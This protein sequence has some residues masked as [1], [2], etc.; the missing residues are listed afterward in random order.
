MADVREVFPILDD[1]GNGAGGIPRK[2]NEGD[3]PTS[4]NGLIGFSFK[5][6]SGNV[7][8]PTLNASGQLP[9]TTGAA[10]TCKRAHGELAAGSATLA[11]VTGSVIT[12][13][14]TKTLSSIGWQVS[15]FRPALFQ[16]VY[17]DDAGGGGETETV[18][19]EA[20]VGPG[21]FSHCCELSCMIVDTSGGTG[22]Q[23]LKVKARNFGGSQSSLR[24]TIAGEE[25]P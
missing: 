9:V 17:V 11:D 5:D 21:N 20:L 4:E 15:C 3:D 13:T 16:L 23:Q 2:M 1:D 8:L 7:V 24:A 22:T 12:I 10:G 14:A 25:S 6:N 18:I 19:A